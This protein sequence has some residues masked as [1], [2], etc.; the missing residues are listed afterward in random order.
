V[1]T[2]TQGAFN[3]LEAAM[4]TRF[5]RLEAK[6]DACNLRHQD[7]TRAHEARIAAH[8]V[9]I[10][11]LREQQAE[12]KRWWLGLLGAVIPTVGYCLWDLITG[13]RK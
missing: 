8:G 4:V 10:D 13:G 3:R 5:D 6:M 2:E 9:Q 1:D 7:S 12:S 11:D